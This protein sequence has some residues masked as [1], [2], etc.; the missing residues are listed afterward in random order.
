MGKPKKATKEQKAR[1][2]ARLKRSVIAF[3]RAIQGA[4]DVGV[5]HKKLMSFTYDIA[6]EDKDKS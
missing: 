4:I 2:L 3:R 1:A 5:T 6:L